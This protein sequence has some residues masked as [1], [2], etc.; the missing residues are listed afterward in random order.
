MC[1][2][3]Y[4]VIQYLKATVNVMP[5]CLGSCGPQAVIRCEGDI[6]PQDKKKKK[7]KINILKKGSQQ[8]SESKRL[9]VLY[10]L[11]TYSISL[12]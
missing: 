6:S 3:L 12:P 5:I 8:T 11:P 9:A 4:V 1:A 10:P 2:C 7:K